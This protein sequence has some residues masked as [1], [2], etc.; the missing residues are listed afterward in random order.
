[1]ASLLES[2]VGTFSEDAI[3]ERVYAAVAL[4]VGEKKILYKTD[5]VKVF[6]FLSFDVFF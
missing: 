2:G 3:Q 5:A 6:I 1:M 4:R